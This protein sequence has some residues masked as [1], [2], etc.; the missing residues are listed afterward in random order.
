M[1]IA[2]TV[3]SIQGKR[4]FIVAEGETRNSTI[5]EGGKLE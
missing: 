1:Y 5:A 2:L 4:R 3:G